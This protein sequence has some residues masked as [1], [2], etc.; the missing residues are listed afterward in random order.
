M[1]C[2]QICPVCDAEQHESY[3]T[4]GIVIRCTLCGL[5]FDKDNEEEEEENKA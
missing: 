3:E 1:A 4:E 5:R 2:E